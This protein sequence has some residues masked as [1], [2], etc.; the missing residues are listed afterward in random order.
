M[1]TLSYFNSVQIVG[2]ER[3]DVQMKKCF[4]KII[5]GLSSMAIIAGVASAMPTMS[6]S[7]YSSTRTI[8]ND[9]I[10]SGYGNYYIH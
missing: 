4:K 1:S 2:Y 10:A 8:D 7:A 5:A 9:S 3:N 6:A